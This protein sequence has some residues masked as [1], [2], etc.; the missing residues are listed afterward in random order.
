MH[1][2]SIYTQR[3]E[4]KLQRRHTIGTAFESTNRRVR[5]TSVSVTKSRKI[6]ITYRRKDR[7]PLE[8]KSL[9]LEFCMLNKLGI[10]H[11]N[12]VVRDLRRSNSRFLTKQSKDIVWDMTSA[13]HSRKFTNET[14]L[15]WSQARFLQ[16]KWTESLC[17]IML[18]QHRQQQTKDM[19]T[20]TDFCRSSGRLLYE[21][22]GRRIEWDVWSK[23][24]RNS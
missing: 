4:T 14:D 24:H 13:T 5:S 16:H 9:M 6:E 8:N 20:K 3:Y 11:N 7:R 2:W 19:F 15:C 22:E 21:E 1:R 23:H 17:E 10:K 18:S 12:K